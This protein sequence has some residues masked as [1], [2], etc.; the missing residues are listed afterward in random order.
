MDEDI[1]KQGILYL[2]QQRFGKKWRRVWSALYRDS[3]CSISRLEFFDC[4]DG[5]VEKS[6]RKQ[7][8]HKKV[9]RL[10]DCIRVSEV[11]VDGCPRDTG[12]FLVETTEKIY[13]FAAE[14]NQVDDWTHKLCETAFPMS[15]TEPSVRRGSVQRGTRVEEDQGMEDN[16]LYSG[17][18]TVRDFRVCVRRTEASDHCRLKGDVILR[19]DDD[20][21]HLLSRTRDVLFTWPFRFLR[22]FGRDK[23]TFSFE[24][25]RRCASGEGGF[26]F[27]T[28]QGNFLF[29]LVESAIQ[30]RRSAP[31]HTQTSGGGQLSPETPHN[32]NLPP[33][34]QSTTLLLPPQPRNHIPPHPAAQDAVYSTV[35]E[36]HLMSHHKESSAPSLPQQRP[37]LCRLEPPV[38]QVLTG[39]KSLTLETRAFPVPRK[40]P[41]K[42]I[43]SCP[44]PH[45][46]PGPA[47]ALGSTPSRDASQ[48]PK[49][50]SNPKPEQTYAQITQLAP[51]ERGSKRERREGG[52]SLA[53]PP[54]HLPQINPEPEYSLPFDTIDKNIMVDFLSSH[55]AL[56]S[57]ADP[58]Y[59][60][61]DEIKIR[62]IIHSKDHAPEPTHRKVDHIYDEPEGCAAA[63]TGGGNST[64]PSA[65]YDDPEEMRGDAWRNMGT[66]DDP[67]GHEYPYDPRVDDYAVP[68]RPKRAFPDTQ[69]TNEEE[70]E[71]EE[72]VQEEEEQRDSQYTN[73]LVK[74]KRL[75][76][77]SSSGSDWF[78]SCCRF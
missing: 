41:V 48:S 31:P 4:K 1:R 35:T 13:V 45:A 12:P 72:E 73:I 15:W 75:H 53:P 51:R 71:D 58:L 34:P 20:A 64:V 18:P 19:V 74:K 26:E 8:E 44:L 32:L 78:P 30:L 49:L 17:T 56:E 16:S 39:V 36:H 37:P 67:K 61:I 28:K 69:D 24:A 60:S 77:P 47:P 33:P 57:G 63:A 40:T 66:A 68:K 25:G 54:G 76:V 70:E 43:S 52:G 5:G 42:M 38:D 21:L 10:S 50:S 59:D 23:S 14:R 27:D 11:E 22:R 65:V 55:Q 46:E 29:Q 3:P 6:L 9:I 2:Q 7:Q 62:N